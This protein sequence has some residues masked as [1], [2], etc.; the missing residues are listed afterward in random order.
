MS[1][2]AISRISPG[3]VDPKRLSASGYRNAKALAMA[4]LAKF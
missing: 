3:G 1:E 4:G 2:G